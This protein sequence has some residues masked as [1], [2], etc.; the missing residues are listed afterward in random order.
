MDNWFIM[1]TIT[2]DITGTYVYQIQKADDSIHLLFVPNYNDVL[3][4]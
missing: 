2:I 1:Y 3:V 4:R